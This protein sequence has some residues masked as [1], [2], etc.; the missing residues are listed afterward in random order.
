MDK[1]KVC[2]GETQPSWLFIDDRAEDVV[3]ASEDEGVDESTVGDGTGNG[4]PEPIDDKQHDE[5]PIGSASGQLD[6]ASTGNENEGEMSSSRPTRQ[7]QP[8]LICAITCVPFVKL[9]VIHRRR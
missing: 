3:A 7:R 4:L 9:L 1:L 6:D 8:R 2:R 5:R